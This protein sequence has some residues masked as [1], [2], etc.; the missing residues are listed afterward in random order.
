[1]FKTDSMKLQEKKKG[2]FC[3]VLHIQL[4]ERNFKDSIAVFNVR[5]FKPMGSLVDMVVA[6]LETCGSDATGSRKVEGKQRIFKIN[7]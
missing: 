4:C 2:V 3:C 5:L 6:V 1:M 7:Q